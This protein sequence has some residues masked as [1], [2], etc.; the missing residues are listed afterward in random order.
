MTGVRSLSL[1]VCSAESPWHLPARSQWAF[2]SSSNRSDL[3]FHHVTLATVQEEF[4]MG[5]SEGN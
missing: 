2:K 3:R 1:Y 5:K 4:E